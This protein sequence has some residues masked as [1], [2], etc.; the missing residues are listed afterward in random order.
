M[1]NFTLYNQ[2]DAPIQSAKL[3]QNV[4]AEL[5]FVPNIHA[6]VAESTIALEG[7]QSL[8]RYFSK[9]DFTATE[10][11]LIQIAV[12]VENGCG[13]CVAG[14]SA[15]AEMLEVSPA[16]V[17][18]LRNNQSLDD[19][20]LEALNQFTRVL[21]RTKGKLSP[22]EVKAFINVGYSQ[23]QL[24]ELVLGI[25]LKTFTNIV[26]SM[27]QL[28]LDEAFSAHVWHSNSEDINSF[29]SKNSSNHH[30]S[31]KLDVPSTSNISATS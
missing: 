23:Q 5:G 10:S 31:P 19:P 22:S 4:N 12:S 8:S 14:H 20:K 3:L 1:Q 29:L 17:Q 25:A 27:S 30:S 26:S 6:M 13:Y 7:F 11:E 21:V 28:P 18:A 24:L 16:V 15:F 9:S 2:H